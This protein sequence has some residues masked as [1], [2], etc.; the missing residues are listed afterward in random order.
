MPGEGLP[1]R[2]GNLLLKFELDMPGIFLC[3]FVRWYLATVE[4]FICDCRRFGV[5][6]ERGR[7]ERGFQVYKL[8]GLE[9]K[10]GGEG[11]AS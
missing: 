4:G 10:K 9:I 2:E 6:G 3:S 8:Y 7:G 1:A 5:Y 11:A